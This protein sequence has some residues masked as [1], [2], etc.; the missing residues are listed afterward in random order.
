MKDIMFSQPAIGFIFEYRGKQV[1]AIQ[2]LLK[3]KI[4]VSNSLDPV[5]RTAIMATAAAMVATLKSGDP[6]CY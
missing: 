2:T 3:Q 4:W 5:M 6:K 1:A